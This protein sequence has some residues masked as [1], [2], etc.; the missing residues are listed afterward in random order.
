MFTKKVVVTA[1]TLVGGWDNLQACATKLVINVVIF[2][3]FKTRMSANQVWLT[4]FILPVC[5]GLITDFIILKILVIEDGM[6]LILANTK[7]LGLTIFIMVIFS[8]FVQAVEG[9]LYG[10]VPCVNPPVTRFVAGI[11]SADSNTGAV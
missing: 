2:T 7:S 9:L 8:A 4:V 6:V 11:I 10:I 3:L 5:V 1:T